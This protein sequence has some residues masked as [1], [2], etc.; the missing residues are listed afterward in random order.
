MALSLTLAQLRE[1]VGDA[2]DVPTGDNRI[3]NAKL[4]RWINQSVQQ[5]ALLKAQY[6]G[7]DIRR[8][9][10][11]GSSSTAVST[12]GFPANQLVALPAGVARIASVFVV[13]NGVRRQLD[14]LQEP[15]KNTWNWSSEIFG[16][17]E[18]FALLDA[19]PSDG[20]AY[21]RVWPPSDAAYTYEVTYAGEPATLALTTDAWVYLPGTQD[22][23]ICDVAKKLMTRDGMQEPTTYQALDQRY[24]QAMANLI[25]ACSSSGT[26][27]SMRDTS[28]TRLPVQRWL[29]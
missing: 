15:D 2:A 18:R 27:R 4:D 9:T 21:L 24:Q 19:S 25:A 1:E 17:P 6:S 26:V 12:Y 23:V 11:T 28:S 29:R 13:F 5:Y 8:A 14:E 20:S 22:L 10:A 7:G 3:T 16:P